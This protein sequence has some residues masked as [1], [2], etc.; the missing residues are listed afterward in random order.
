MSG[1]YPNGLFSAASFIGFLLSV[2]PFP[3]HFE[4]WNTGTCLYMAWTGVSCMNQ[5]INSVLWTNNVYNWSP[6]WCDISSRIIIAANFGIPA[7]SLCINRRL[8]H[9]SSVRSIT[10][11]KDEK[12]RAV[13]VD[14]AIGLGLPLIFTVLQYIP[15]G[16]RFDIWEDVGCFPFTYNTLVGIFIVHVP[17]IFFGLVAGIYA[18]LTIRSFVQLR[19]QFK[20]VLSKCNNLTT[21]RYLRLV[22]LATVEVIGTIPL[23]A[24]SISFN[25]RQMEPWISWEDTHS[26]FSQIRQIPAA[27]WRNSP[28]EPGLEFT[29]WIHIA[30]AILFFSLFGFAE[31]AMKNYRLAASTVA[32][33]VGVSTIG[34][35]S[36]SGSFTSKWSKRSFPSTTPSKA[37]SGRGAVLPVFVKHDVLRKHDS[38]DSFSDGSDFSKNNGGL[39]EKDPKNAVPYDSI[40]LPDLGGALADADP[41]PLSPTVHHSRPGAYSIEVSSVR[42]SGHIDEAYT[43]KN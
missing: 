23:G 5:F 27:V 42:Y 6:V 41:A 34:T 12:R 37:N 40:V 43:K 11:T 4:A 17:P 39:N 15:Q 19:C 18:I 1:S 25:V 2:I 24:L 32:K 26:N 8:Y 9:I 10:I 7:S 29:R 16:H 21:S 30:L 14:L 28:A 35:G 3:W 38:L 13:M 31:E 33:Y 22:I 20:E 36:G